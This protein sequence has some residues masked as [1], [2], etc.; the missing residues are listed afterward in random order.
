MDYEIVL[1]D[2]YTGTRYELT[3][4]YGILD[5][6]ESPKVGIP[7]LVVED[8]DGSGQKWKIYVA[9][10][11][12]K[13]DTVA[14]ITELSENNIVYDS[15]D[16]LY[17]EVT[18][19]TGIQSVIEAHPIGPTIVTGKGGFGP[20]VFRRRNFLSVPIL[21]LIKREQKRTVVLEAEK[22]IPSCEEFV[23]FGKRLK[24]KVK[25]LNLIGEKRSNDC[26]ILE[27]IE[28]KKLQKV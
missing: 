28:D 23:I 7:E 2:V 14:D 22:S 6:S 11:V 5:H 21:A 9:N 1:E 27:V 18:V 10:G 3:V 15:G 4:N 16:S 25:T 24:D 17:Y 26:C 19:R 12:L 13:W 8:G 20:A